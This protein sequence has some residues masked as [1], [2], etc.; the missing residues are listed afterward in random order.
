MTVLIIVAIVPAVGYLIWVRDTETCR[1]EPYSALI[2]VMIY[3]GT[4]AVAAAVILETLVQMALYL[5]GSPLSRGFG[6]FGPFDPTLEAILLAV[7]I[8]PV[9]EE[10][11]KAT[12][13]FTVYGR[14]N[15]I[16]DGIV[17]GEA[18]GLG[19][20]VTENV[21]YFVVAFSQGLDVL[22]VTVV[23][24]SITSMVLHLSAT[25]ISGYGISRARILGSH[26]RPVGWLRYVG[27]AIVLHASFN[28]IASLGDIF[29]QNSDI[30]G[31]AG[32]ILVFILA[33]A[34]FGIMRK[35]IKQLDLSTACQTPQAR[36]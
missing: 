17:Y 6:I 13:V 26:G 33:N 10:L 15:E 12:G 35:R 34:A 7:I 8:A 28:L 20:A 9:V 5:P 25:S 22:F 18:V 36:L 30:L 14:L 27:I 16:E 1:R 19:F 4:F 32:L 31:L 21:L 2:G 29:Q 11:V 3:G 24:R 23:I